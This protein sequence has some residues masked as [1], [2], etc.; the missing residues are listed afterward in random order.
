[1]Y[2]AHQSLLLY[3]TLSTIASQPP[4]THEAMVTVQ[5]SASASQTPP[6]GDHAIF[7]LLCL[8][9]FI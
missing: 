6:E 8:A 5:L 4:H 7:F 1:M 2:V 9:Y 3:L